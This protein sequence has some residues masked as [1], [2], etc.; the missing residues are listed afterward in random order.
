VLQAL[1]LATWL[2]NLQG[3]GTDTD[4][5]AHDL[6]LQNLGTQV[7]THSLVTRGQARH[8]RVE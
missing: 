7:H 2:Q 3:D 4:L 1:L 5:D 6:V 8:P